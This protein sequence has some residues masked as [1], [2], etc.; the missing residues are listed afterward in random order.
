[1]RISNNFGSKVN[2]NLGSK[3]NKVLKLGMLSL[4]IPC[5]APTTLAADTVQLS[6]NAVLIK[7]TIK[8][9]TIPLDSKKPSVI[10]DT[11]SNSIKKL[12]VGFGDS[13]ALNLIKETEEAFVYKVVDLSALGLPPNALE[14]FDTVFI[15]ESKNPRIKPVYRFDYKPKM[16]TNDPTTNNIPYT[17]FVHDYVGH[18][19]EFRN[20]IG[21][22]HG[23]GADYVVD[24]VY[25]KSAGIGVLEKSMYKGSEEQHSYFRIDLKGNKTTEISKSDYSKTFQILLHDYDS[26]LGNLE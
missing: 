19:L 11:D 17:L 25:E 1:M 7:K 12:A 24:R 10:S 21:V 8:N 22:F 9:I 26:L 16:V 4:M 5:S 13:P 14:V 6:H 2:T 20:E 18:P 23:N 15:A 3:I